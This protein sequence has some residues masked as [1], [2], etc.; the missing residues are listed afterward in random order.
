MNSLC[1]ADGSPRDASLRGLAIAL[2]NRGVRT[3]RNG[4]WQVS[5]VRNILARSSP[6]NLLY[7]GNYPGEQSCC[8][9]APSAAQ[10]G[11]P[12]GCARSSLRCTNGNAVR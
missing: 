2:N 3:A 12:C 8:V 10:R 9:K 11:I 4:Q 5:N 7:R 6:A 1:D